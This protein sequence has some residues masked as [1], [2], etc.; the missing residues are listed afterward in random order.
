MNLRLVQFN[1][2]PGQ[3]AAAETIADKV[4]PAIR[5]QSGCERSEFFMDEAS[6]DYGIVVLWASRKAADAAAMVIGP[7]LSSLLADAKAVG[8]NRRLYEVYEPKAA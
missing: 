5:A 8:D 6:G 4:I 7:L 2:G 3:R 1:L